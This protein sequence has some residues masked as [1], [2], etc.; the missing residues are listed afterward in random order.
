MKYLYFFS[1]L[2]V[3]C[4]AELK[5]ETTN[6][7]EEEEVYLEPV[8]LIPADD[9]QQIEVGDKACN[10]RLTDQNGE[11]WDLYSHK[12]DVILLDFSTIWC[13]PCQMAGHS[14]QSIQDEYETEGFQFVTV[15]LQGS[16]GEEPTEQEI[17]IWVNEHNITSAPILQ[18]SNEK[19]IDSQATGTVESPGVTGY[20]LNGYPTYIYIDREMKFYSGHVGFSADHVRQTIEQGL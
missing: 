1:A 4:A 3:G 20:L 8:G 18:G 14:T 10:F 17:E 19:M 12:G 15:I 7:I 16:T 13:Y 6:S 9:C 5:T 11:T 2:L